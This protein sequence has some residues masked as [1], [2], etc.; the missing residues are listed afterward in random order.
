MRT[1]EI[2][3]DLSVRHGRLF[4]VVKDRAPL[5][6]ARVGGIHFLEGYAEIRKAIGLPPAKGS[7]SVPDS[8]TEMVDH[9]IATD[10]RE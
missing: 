10:W 8:I 7:D 2:L 9:I 5:L 4:D 6:S 3:M 1:H